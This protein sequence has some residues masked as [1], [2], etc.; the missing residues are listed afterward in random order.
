MTW[1]RARALLGWWIT[2]MV[3]DMPEPEVPVLI[4]GAGPVGLS[5]AI[6]LARHG[7]QTRLVERHPSTTN[8]PKLRAVLTRTMEVL[9]PWSIDPALRA[10]ALPPGGYRFIWVESLSGR[11]IGRV[12]PP[13]R[14]VPG[15]HSPTHVCV[16]GQDAFEA[17]LR[18]HAETYPAQ[19]DVQFNTELVAV[20]QDSNGV[21]ASLR[22]RRTDQVSIA[23][24][25][26]LIAADGAS[27]PVRDML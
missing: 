21:T 22:D 16:V 18:R 23:R 13:L 17:E 20:D 15:P 14:D 10:E 8:H 1:R 6:L 11:E 7:V 25:A 27:S 2:K 9:R 4:V 5:A 19:I 3:A 26:Y 12:E 24:A